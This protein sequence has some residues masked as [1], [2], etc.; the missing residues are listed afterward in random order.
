MKFIKISYSSISNVLQI[1]SLYRIFIPKKEE[2]QEQ[3]TTENN[4]KNPVIIATVVAVLGILGILGFV[5]SRNSTVQKT[6]EVSPSESGSSTGA[7]DNLVVPTEAE[8]QDLNQR[9]IEGSEDVQDTAEVRTIEVTAGGFYYQPAEIR[10]KQG[11]T[12]RVE[13]KSV[14]MMHDFVIDELGVNI[15]I[16]QA[17]ESNSVEF[18]ADTK[19]TFQYYCSVGN[20]RTQGQVGTIIVE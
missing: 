4:S 13:M 8:F 11:E 19:G 7:P 18:T 9:V 15:P 1:I 3:V 16:T 20:H 10:V 17:G 12:V 2:M 14:D 6:Q 5:M